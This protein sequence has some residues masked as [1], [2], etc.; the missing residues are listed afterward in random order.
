MSMVTY[1]GMK[2]LSRDQFQ[3]KIDRCATS[4]GKIGEF[5]AGL[6]LRDHLDLLVT[7][8]GCRNIVTAFFW[9]VFAGANRSMEY[10]KVL[11]CHIYFKPDRCTKNLQFLNHISSGELVARTSLTPN[12][13]PGAQIPIVSMVNPE[14][15]DSVGD[16]EFQDSEDNPV[17]VDSESNINSAPIEEDEPVDEF[18]NYCYTPPSGE[19]EVF[20]HCTRQATFE[21]MKNKLKNLL[22]NENKEYRKELENFIDNICKI[23]GGGQYSIP[24]HHLN[25]FWNS[26]K[27][28]ITIL[29]DPK[30]NISEEFKN[31]VFSNVVIY[32]N[33][34]DT[35]EDAFVIAIDGVEIIASITK[36]VQ[37]SNG[38]MLN[39]GYV[40]EVL[41]SKH[42]TDIFDLSIVDVE[43]AIKCWPH[44]MLE[45]KIFI[46]DMI[47][48]IHL[49]FK[50]TMKPIAYFDCAAN[51]LTALGEKL[52]NNSSNSLV[53]D[54]IAFSQKYDKF[55]SKF[56]KLCKFFKI[57]SDKQCFAAKVIVATFLSKINNFLVNNIAQNGGA[58]MLLK[59]TDGFQNFTFQGEHLDGLMET[60]DSYYQLKGDSCNNDDRNF[61][62]NF[63]D[64]KTWANLKE[65]VLENAI[66]N[67]DNDCVRI[68]NL[69][70][71]MFFSGDMKAAVYDSYIAIKL[72]TSYLSNEMKKKGNNLWQVYDKWNRMPMV[73][74]S[75]RSWTGNTR[76]TNRLF[77]NLRDNMP[78]EEIDSLVG[79]LSD[80]EEY[81]AFLEAVQEYR[82][83]VFVRSL[84]RYLTREDCISRIAVDMGNFGEYSFV[85]VFLC[86][87]EYIRNGI[88]PYLFQEN[89]I[90]DFVGQLV[91]AA[92]GPMWSYNTVLDVVCCFLTVRT[93]MDIDQEND[94]QQS[95]RE[96]DPSIVRLR[97]EENAKRTSK[98]L[99]AITKVIAEKQNL[100]NNG[101]VEF[102]INQIDHYQLEDIYK[103]TLEMFSPKCMSV[104][105]ILF[106]HNFLEFWNDILGPI[107]ERN[108][109]E[110]KAAIKKILGADVTFTHESCVSSHRA[111]NTFLM[112]LHA[113]DY[114]TEIK[115]EQKQKMELADK[116]CEWVIKNYTQEELQHLL[117]ALFDTAKHTL[118]RDFAEHRGYGSVNNF[119][120]H[121]KTCFTTKLC[122]KAEYSRKYMTVNEKEIETIQVG[123]KLFYFKECDTY[124][125]VATGH[126]MPVDEYEN[127]EISKSI[128]NIEGMSG[129]YDKQHKYT[130]YILKQVDDKVAKELLQKIKQGATGGPDMQL[131]KE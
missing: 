92:W 97:L 90:Y 56:S 57:S 77:A 109:E 12:E 27:E 98:F 7:Y 102:L 6:S 29:D 72:C 95:E 68:T 62:R 51:V 64:G 80:M 43:T 115:A 78:R 28:I 129:E 114:T 126:F 25:R 104:A 63:A 66:N 5:L 83:K 99:L 105:D 111:F 10:Y 14:V 42:A 93:N 54:A 128:R 48:Q 112:A 76:E 69:F 26:F 47:G 108:D 44:E 50:W 130:R 103:H 122:N 9:F 71:P 33:Y 4:N 38:G 67:D 131:N 45:G 85:N 82:C 81:T 73:A 39:I 124:R 8:V 100:T 87:P 53:K 121:I 19:N 91:G 75:F 32:A 70:F 41:L 3:E 89:Y 79:A 52:S 65:E 40:L 106:C 113:Q 107:S 24:S 88:A 34:F 1:G 101:L 11:A 59:M 16:S 127:N 96:N 123:S 35:C 46:N 22:K 84:T 31:F 49:P 60:F 118:F 86:T 116:L 119:S 110:G 58:R 13:E 120:L 94:A 36:N 125:Q 74:N 20:W 17:V 23:A 55:P 18:R 15:N 37:S 117:D 21:V 30:N 61:F 2:Y